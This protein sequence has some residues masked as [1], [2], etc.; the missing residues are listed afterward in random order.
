[1]LRVIVDESG[2]GQVADSA[3]PGGFDLDH[4]AIVAIDKWQFEPARQDGKPL[5]VYIRVRFDFNYEN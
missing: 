3:T 4:A 5:K 1:V 2:K